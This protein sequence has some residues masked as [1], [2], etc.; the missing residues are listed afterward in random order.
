M[1][2]GAFSNRYVSLTHAS[3]HEL[4]VMQLAVPSMSTLSVASLA[5]PVEPMAE[6]SALALGDAMHPGGPAE[7]LLAVLGSTAHMIQTRCRTRSGSSPAAVASQSGEHAIMTRPSLVCA[8]LRSATD[9]LDSPSLSLPWRFVPGWR[10]VVTA[11]CA[12]G[13]EG[14]IWAG[15]HGGGAL[16]LGARFPR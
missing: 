5:S 11:S 15:G 3:P 16:K 1:T 2:A 9:F 4:G 12:S 7:F 8:A 6:V 10:A 14:E 13:R